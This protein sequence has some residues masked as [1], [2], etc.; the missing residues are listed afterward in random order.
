MK[1]Q[2]I[3]LL[4]LMSNGLIAQPSGKKNKD[5]SS[6]SKEVQSITNNST[7]EAINK[8]VEYNAKEL[9]HYRNR[10]Q[11][12]EIDS[13]E[14]SK[15]ILPANMRTGQGNNIPVNTVKVDSMAMY[16]ALIG[17]LK[18]S[19]QQQSRK[20]LELK[21]K[22]AELNEY[23]AQIYQLYNK[24]FDSL[25][26]NITESSMERD[27]KIF[28]KTG[29]VPK[30]YNDLKI[31][32]NAK[33]VL[34]KRFNQSLVDIHLKELNKLGPSNTIEDLKNNLSYFSIL[35][36]S[37][38]TTLKSIINDIDAQKKA[39]GLPA[40]EATKKKDIMSKMAEFYRD[41]EWEPGVYTY[42]ER[43]IKKI[44]KDKVRN[45]DTDIS[46]YLSQL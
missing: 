21:Q 23:V 32:Y 15:L 36:N 4:L 41:N 25:V 7:I 26:L 19:L 11:Q 38:I 6:T 18:D 13:V 27:N 28:T 45:P 24:P 10:L 20:M 2:I 16:R 3:V 33:R 9:L 44:L 39:S 12:L 42:V 40:V 5:M 35:N 29:S 8:C 17:Q 14:L 30:G 22:E 43:V 31:Y 1:N 37:L 46:S 34:D